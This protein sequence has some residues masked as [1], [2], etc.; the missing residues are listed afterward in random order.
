MSIN[1]IGNLETA[2]REILEAVRALRYG[3]VEISVHDGRVVQIE[4]REKVR[5][6]AGHKVLCWKKRV[7]HAPIISRSAAFRLD[8]GRGQ[9]LADLWA[10]ARPVDFF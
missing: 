8:P 4:T 10:Q 5:F 7:G 2:E 1:N 3:S 6:E 9:Q